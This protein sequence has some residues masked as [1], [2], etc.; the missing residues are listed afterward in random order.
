[1][2][3]RTIV[4]VLGILALLSTAT[5]GYL[6]YQTA[7]EAAFKETGNELLRTVE[8]LKNDVSGLIEVSQNQ[9]GLLARFEQLHEAL[10]LSLIHI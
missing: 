10:L 5:G 4:L 7:R 3:V 6:L 8:D 2:N 1:M 9:A